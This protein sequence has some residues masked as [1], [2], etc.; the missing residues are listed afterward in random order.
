MVYICYCNRTAS[1]TESSLGEAVAGTSM[2]AGTSKSD[3]K[4]EELLQ[5]APVVPYGADLEHWENPDK[6]EAPLV[7]K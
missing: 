6:M 5:K 2:I 3:Q 1:A 7:I 4:K